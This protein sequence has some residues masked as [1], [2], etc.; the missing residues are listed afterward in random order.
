MK[1][2]PNDTRAPFT[3]AMLSMDKQDFVAAE[4]YFKLAI[5][6]GTPTEVPICIFILT[7]M[8]PSNYF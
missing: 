6:L 8:Y 3:L 5:T 1:R 2:S 7:K 4:K